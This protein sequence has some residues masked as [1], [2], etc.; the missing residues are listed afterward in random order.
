MTTSPD[1]AAAPVA[2]DPGQAAVTTL[3]AAALIGLHLVI[4]PSVYD[5]SQLPRLWALL[6][7]LLVAVPAVLWLPSLARR[8]DARPLADPLV[9]AAA[10]YLVIDVLSLCWSVNI[11]AGFTDVF[12][13][14]GS[15]L[16]LCLCLLLFPLAR[17]WQA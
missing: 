17:D 11:S 3:L 16:V 15:V 2:F 4:D 8:L 6:A 9:I 12:R 14:L 13:T 5:V 7:A 1:P 10:A